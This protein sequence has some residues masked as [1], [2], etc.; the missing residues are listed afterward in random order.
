[1]FSSTGHGHY[2]VDIGGSMPTC[3][4]PVFFREELPCKHVFAV[5]QKSNVSWDDLPETFRLV[6][7][8]R[9]IE[10]KEFNKKEKEIR[11]S[12]KK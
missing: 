7:S 8:H 2:N 4:C 3:Q 1:M 12:L 5:L 9:I 6:T 10:A 11:R